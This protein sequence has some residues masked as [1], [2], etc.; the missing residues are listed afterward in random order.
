MSLIATIRKDLMQAKKDGDKQKS[1]CLSF[2]LGESE[3]I[4]KNQGNRESTDEEVCSVIKKM[5]KT[6]EETLVLVAD[7]K[8]SVQNI[9]GEISIYRKYLP[10]QMSEEDLRECIRNLISEMNG[11]G[12][13]PN[14][15]AIMKT[16]KANLSGGYD[17]AMASRIA[18]EEI[19]G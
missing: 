12:T 16:L 9:E 8:D 14:V 4:G 1:Q 15:G 2:L 3:K 5:I 19:G 7:R 6:M 18:K 11:H 13:Q 17:G 10:A